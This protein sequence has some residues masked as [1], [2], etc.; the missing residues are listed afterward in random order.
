[1]KIETKISK[2]NS[3][4]NLSIDD[5]GFGIFIPE[6][7]NRVRIIMLESVNLYIDSDGSVE[8]FEP[9]SWDD[10][11]FMAAPEGD[12]TSITFTQE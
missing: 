12:K 3:A 8:I 10:V 4:F 7:D 5:C 2:S 9:T 6:S 1:M 11:K